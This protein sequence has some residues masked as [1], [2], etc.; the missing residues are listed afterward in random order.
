MPEAAD[1]ASAAARSRGG[2]GFAAAAA[3]FCAAAVLALYWPALG[4]EFIWDD[5]SYLIHSP[6]LRDPSQ[7]RD[8]LFRPSTGEAV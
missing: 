5:R 6:A 4:F 2:G 7:W 3:G 8:A 1:T